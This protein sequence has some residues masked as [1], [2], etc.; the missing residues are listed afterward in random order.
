MD[1]KFQYQGGSAPGYLALPPGG[2]GHAVL[3]CHAWWG[4]NAFFKSLCD[5][6]AGAGFVAFA[7]DLYAGEAAATIEG[8][9]A[10]KQ[11][12]DRSVVNKQ[13]KGAV[14]YLTGQ[15]AAAGD[16]IGVLGCSLGA[17]YAYWLSDN[18]PADVAA[19]VAFYGV[20]AGTFSRTRAS[21]LGHYAE[22]DD[23]GAGPAKV[24]KLRDKLVG[25]GCEVTFHTYPGTRHWFFESDVSDAYQPEAA[26]LAWDRTLTFLRE[27]L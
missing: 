9:Q 15:D 1:T 5:R 20:G 11:S 24:S 6:L 2:A 3:V 8:A 22:K 12:L 13:L 17:H 19:V 26:A 18:C 21:Y 23:W 27:R 4:L 14:R 10:L 7:P 25:Q 16:R